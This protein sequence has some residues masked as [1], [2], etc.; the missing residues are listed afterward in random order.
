MPSAVT[1]APDTVELARN[2]NESGTLYAER[3]PDDQVLIGF[4][5]T[6]DAPGG[7]TYLRSAQ[8]ICGA[9]SVTS[10]PPYEVK[11]IEAEALPMR[12]IAS[13]QFE[14]AR[15]P[16]NQ[17]M[18]GF[19]GRSGL[20]MDS[21]DVRCAPLSILG[22]APTYLLVS[23][24]P[25]TAGTI[26]GATGGS[27]FDPMECEAGQVAV[28][29]VVRTIYSGQLLGAFGVQCAKLELVTRHD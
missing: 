23:G 2:L 20:W 25:A 28:G 6:V 21:V 14:A 17:V 9:L 10:S 4:Q 16:V 11:V 18:I 12:E 1:L 26:G 19:A 27:P 29:Q 5:G 3:C 13:A 8:A 7:A 24:T 15:C 22:V